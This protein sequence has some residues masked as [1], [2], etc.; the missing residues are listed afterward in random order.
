MRGLG[1]ENL[2][3]QRW[4]ARDR[5]AR[6]NLSTLKP[7]FGD[8]HT[9]WSGM[10]ITCLGHADVVRCYDGSGTLFSRAVCA[11]MAQVE[12]RFIL[13]IRCPTICEVFAGG[14]EEAVRAA[15]SVA[16]KRS[17]GNTAA[18]C[19]E[20]AVT[21]RKCR[22]KS[23]KPIRKAWN[24]GKWPRTP[25]GDSCRWTGDQRC[26]TACFLVEHSGA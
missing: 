19:C 25:D 21:R 7:L 18:R 13:S 10:V 20:T 2:R 16:R 6:F 1:W 22:R 17:A 4:R 23:L 24:G 12:G 3:A 5:P 26:P 8:M 15:A 14:A 11:K 9:R